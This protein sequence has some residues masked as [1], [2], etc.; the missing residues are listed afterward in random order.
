MNGIPIKEVLRLLRQAER[1]SEENDL[2]QIDS[3]N[4]AL[5]KIGYSVV[6]KD[7]EAYLKQ[8]Y[9]GTG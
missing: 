4:A 6:V 3:I 1:A 9:N 5:E 7:G 8:S 2:A